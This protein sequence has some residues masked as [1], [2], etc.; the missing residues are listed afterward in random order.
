[1]GSG[2][3]E[4]P[5]GRFVEFIPGGDGRREA[6][7]SNFIGSEKLLRQIDQNKFLA[8]LSRRIDQR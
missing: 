3:T 8:Q 2:Q 5:R 4:L 1:M 7:G 6:K